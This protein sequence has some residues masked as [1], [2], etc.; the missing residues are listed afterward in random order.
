MPKT[1]LSIV[2]VMRQELT[3]IFQ[4]GKNSYYQRTPTVSQFKAT[5]LTISS[6]SMKLKRLTKL[7]LSKL[8]VKSKKC[9]VHDHVEE[10]DL[11]SDSNYLFCFR[12]IINR[13]ASSPSNPQKR[14]KSSN[15]VD[16]HLRLSH[17]ATSTLQ[18]I[19]GR[20]YQPEN[21]RCTACILI[22]MTRSP[23]PKRRE[24]SS[25]KLELVHSDLG[26]LNPPS[27][28]GNSTS[29]MMDGTSLKNMIDN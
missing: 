19:F 2:K 11:D 17:A 22:K 24:Q 16:W 14:K 21:T 1:I 27:H 25:Q 4:E 20:Y 3:P 18:R 15:E 7:S 28:G 6:T 12:R 8:G 26:G 10:D 23:F 13:Q 5:R 29:L 9:F